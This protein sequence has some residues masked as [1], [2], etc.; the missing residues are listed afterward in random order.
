MQQLFGAL[1]VNQEA[2]NEFFAALTGSLPVPAFMNP[3][4]VGRIVAGATSS[5]R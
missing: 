4:N 5:S 2:T 3:E 1:H